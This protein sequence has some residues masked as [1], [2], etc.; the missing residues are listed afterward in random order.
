MRV[1]SGIWRV[2]T[3]PGANFSW[4]LFYGE[5]SNFW[6]DGLTC[7]QVL[8]KTERREVIWIYLTLHQAVL[9][10]EQSRGGR[11]GVLWGS[12]SGGKWRISVERLWR[13]VQ[14]W[15]GDELCKYMKYVPIVPNILHWQRNSEW[16]TM[17]CISEIKYP[18]NIF[19]N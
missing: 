17:E 18:H 9:R 3:K 2:A 14:S 10:P 13:K 8:M 7:W 16:R 5:H 11:R 19:N 12:S 15:C 1:T 4:I 6:E